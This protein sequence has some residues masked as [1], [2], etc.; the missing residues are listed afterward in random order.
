M[1]EKTAKY[2]RRVYDSSGVT[3]DVIAEARNA[4]SSSFMS[5]LRSSGTPTF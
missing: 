4:G 3:L 5:S 2:E 1:S